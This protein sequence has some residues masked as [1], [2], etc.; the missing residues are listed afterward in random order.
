MKRFS[1][2]QVGRR[3]SEQAPKG[4]PPRLR[5]LSSSPCR[6]APAPAG[7]PVRLQRSLIHAGD[8]IDGLNLVGAEDEPGSACALGRLGFRHFCSTGEDVDHLGI[9]DL[10]EIMVVEA[11]RPEPEHGTGLPPAKPICCRSAISTSC[12]PCRPKSPRSPIRTRRWSIVCCSAQPPRRYLR[13]PPIPS[14][15]ALASAPPPCS[16]PGARRRPTIR[17]FI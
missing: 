10:V 9:A 16:T 7:E 4:R 1:F 2:E 11:D 3:P 14:T 13:S 15:S 6:A 17:M 12:S 8:L 5:R